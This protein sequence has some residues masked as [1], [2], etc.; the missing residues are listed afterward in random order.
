MA[1]NDR[2]HWGSSKCPVPMTGAWLSPKNNPTPFNQRDAL[3]PQEAFSSRP[4][5]LFLCF[6]EALKV[7]GKTR[8]YKL[9]KGERILLVRTVHP[10]VGLASKDLKGF[11]KRALPISGLIQCY[12]AHLTGG[13]AETQSNP[14]S[15]QQKIG[16]QLPTLP[17]R[18]T[19]DTRAKHGRV[20]VSSQFAAIDFSGTRIGA[21]AS[22]VALI[23]RQ[24]KAEELLKER[25][26]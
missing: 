21:A 9:A 3:K 12:N 4:L 14:A 15:Q 5:S 19:R 8:D 11:D 22:N 24:S 26:S 16:V 6:S 2:F 20:K 23:K 10:A 13:E 17:A 7:L 1:F 25:F 18:P